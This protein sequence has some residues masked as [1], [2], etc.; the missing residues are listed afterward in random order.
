MK[1][2]RYP[3]HVPKLQFQIIKEIA[4]N[5][6]L[7]NSKLK[8][9]LEVTHPVVSE[10]IKVLMNRNLVKISH[11]ESIEHKDGKPETYYTLTK[12][13]LEEFI[14]RNPTPEEFFEALLKSHNLR[15]QSGWLTPMSSED[16]EHY[17]RLFEQNYL[18]YFSTHGYLVQSPFFNQLY[19]QWLAEY[20][21][22]LFMQNHLNNIIRLVHSPFIEKC[23]E[24]SLTDPDT[25]AI[26][27]IKNDIRDAWKDN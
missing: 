7:S 3:K 4:L 25:E 21:P 26:S 16:F 15:Q 19:E 10:A 18:G 17:Y 2:R 23:Y 9:R 5:E 6:H 11:L 1:P 22:G 27:T 24:E 8:E 13:G 14:K 20:R 12:Q